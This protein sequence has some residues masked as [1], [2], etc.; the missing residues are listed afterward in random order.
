MSIYFTDAEI[1]QLADL[2]EEL[3][4]HPINYFF[5]RL[6][7]FA[8]FKD[9]CE[10]MLSLQWQFLSS[11]LNLVIEAFKA[12]GKAI[13]MLFILNFSLAGDEFC[14]ATNVALAG[15]AKLGLD[16]FFLLLHIVRLLTV[17]IIAFLPEFIAFNATL[18]FGLIVFPLV[19]LGLSQAIGA[20]I[21]IGVVA[22]VFASCLRYLMAEPNPNSKRKKKLHSV[23]ELEEF[24]RD[25]EKICAEKAK[26]IEVIDDL[27]AIKTRRELSTHQGSKFFLK[28]VEP[29]TTYQVTTDFANQFNAY[30]K[31]CDERVKNE[32]DYRD[33]IHQELMEHHSIVMGLKEECF[34]QA[35]IV[36]YRISVSSSMQNTS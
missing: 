10:S 26:I 23:I 3:L 34:R 33:I 2:Q 32:P 30:P 29:S 14:K 25:F 12:L 7:N 5:K 36:D 1:E 35:G 28:S 18:V 6:K 19:G 8:E 15:L 31:F 4:V 22:P 24:N 17:L 21:V 16:L 20:G 9:I 27:R 11:G 13:Y